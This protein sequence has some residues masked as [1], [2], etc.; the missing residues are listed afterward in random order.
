MIR[1]KMNETQRRFDANGNDV[2]DI[3][4]LDDAIRVLEDHQARA[5]AGD[6][7]AQQLIQDAEARARDRAHAAQS[8]SS[9]GVSAM[10]VQPVG[11]NYDPDANPVDDT[12]NAGTAASAE[13]VESGTKRRERRTDRGQ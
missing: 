1:T 11:E 13:T 9:G 3:G 12:A 2:T 6:P 4:N 5:A 8:L 7:H 10:D